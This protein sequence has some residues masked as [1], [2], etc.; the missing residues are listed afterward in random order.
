MKKRLRIAHDADMA[1]PKNKVAALQAGKHPADRQG[2]A[3]RFSNDFLCYEFLPPEQPEDPAS[4]CS[5]NDADLL[6]RCTCRT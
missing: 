2:R 5:E 6:K 3:N 4:G 1:G